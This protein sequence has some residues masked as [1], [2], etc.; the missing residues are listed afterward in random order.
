VR[1]QRALRASRRVFAPVILPACLVRPQ[2]VDQDDQA[3]IGE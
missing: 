3:S 1:H 2:V